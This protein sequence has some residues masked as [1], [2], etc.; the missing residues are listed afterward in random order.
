MHLIN[1]ERLSGDGTATRGVGISAGIC[2]WSLIRR[3]S[4]TEGARPDSLSVVTARA[5]Q[6][7]PARFNVL[8][9]PGPSNDMCTLRAGAEPGNNAAGSRSACAEAT[10]IVHRG[11]SDSGRADVRGSMWPRRA[12]RRLP[13]SYTE[14]RIVPH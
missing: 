9:P 10:P 13:G 3:M 7:T 11:S 6:L 4:A 1:V 5:A 12:M 8:N 2:K 14:G